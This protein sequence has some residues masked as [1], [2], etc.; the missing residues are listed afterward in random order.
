MVV[1]CPGWRRMQLV[2]GLW[3]APLSRGHPGH[4]TNLARQRFATA[5][6]KHRYAQLDTGKK[7]HTLHMYAHTCSKKRQLS[8]LD[9]KANCINVNTSRILTGLVLLYTSLES[10]L[11]LVMIIL[12]FCVCSS[13]EPSLKLFA[14][15]LDRQT[16]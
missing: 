14:S 11:L 8:W 1:A 12:N 9:I 10:T 7:R 2:A 13:I 3:R 4:H 5:G 15:G 16:H 6:T